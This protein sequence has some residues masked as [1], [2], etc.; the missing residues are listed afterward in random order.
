MPDL[1]VVTSA[2]VQVF[3]GREV[4]CSFDFELQL[5]VGGVPKDAT[6]RD[7]DGDGFAEIVA[8]LDDGTVSV[9][10]GEDGVE[11]SEPD[12][13]RK[14]PGAKDLRRPEI[15]DLNGDGF[16]DIV[17]LDAHTAKLHVFPGLG[18]YGPIW[19]G[20]PLAIPLTKGTSSIAIRDLDDD[21]CK[22]ILALSPLTKAVVV[23]RN[24]TAYPDECGWEAPP[25]L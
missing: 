11:F 25:V 2:G 12:V 13:S 19:Q 17:V 21:H 15:T 7:L 10:H 18:K 4:T 9:L 24:I 20:T 5:G 6:A 14:V 8:T 23:L 1:L 22:E 16:P 3:T